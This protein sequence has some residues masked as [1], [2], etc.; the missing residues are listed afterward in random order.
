MQKGLKYIVLL[1]LAMTISCTKENQ[2]DCY[3][4][5]RLHFRFTL[6][7]E[8]EKGNLFGSNIKHLKVYVFDK[9]GILQRIETEKGVVLTNDY[10]M[11]LD[12]E[13]G[14]YSIVAWACDNDDFFNTHNQRQIIDPSQA[15]FAY[16]ELEVGAS[17]I[18][19][20]RILLKSESSE[21]Y[22]EDTKPTEDN[23]DDLFFGAVGTRSRRYKP[24]HHHSCGGWI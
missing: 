13:P 5:V 10:V 12:L 21:D 3:F 7:E 14:S 8:P 16:K 2:E 4:G 1:L 18:E 23:F 24:V 22:P 9:S 6:H 11:S 19:D 15:S 20:L 17:R